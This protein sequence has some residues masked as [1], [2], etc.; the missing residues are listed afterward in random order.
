M[1]LAAQYTR[2]D[3]GMTPFNE[4][5]RCAQDDKSSVVYILSML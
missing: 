1:T 3:T 4:I 2:N 5:L